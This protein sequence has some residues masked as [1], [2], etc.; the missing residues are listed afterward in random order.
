[1]PGYESG[2]E[3][4]RSFPLKGVIRAS[5]RLSYQCDGIQSLMQA[6]LLRVTF[7]AKALPQGEARDRGASGRAS[8]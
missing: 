3:G 1:M 5:V 6:R 4:R 8:G 7:A 2:R